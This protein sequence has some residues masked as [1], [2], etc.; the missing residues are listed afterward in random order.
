MSKSDTRAAVI[1]KWSDEAAGDNDDDVD[2]DNH[3]NNDQNN[4]NSGRDAGKL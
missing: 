1:G 3:N 4:N 2:C